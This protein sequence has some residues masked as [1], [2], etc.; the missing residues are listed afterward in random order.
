M[1]TLTRRRRRFGRYGWIDAM[2][3]GHKTGGRQKGTRNKATVRLDAKLAEAAG[4]ATKGLSP[5]EIVTM[6][7][8]EIMLLAMRLEME[9][10]TVAVGGHDRREGG[11]IRP[12]KNGSADGG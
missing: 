12:S 5:S 10:G 4:W 8:L 3:K 1:V 11:S 6:M 2:A 9:K 7:P